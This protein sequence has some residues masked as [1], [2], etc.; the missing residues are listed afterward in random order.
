MLLIYF[1][2][3]NRRRRQQL[4][5]YLDSVTYDVETAKNDTLVNFPMPMVAFKLE[6]T[7]LVWGNHMF[8]DIVGDKHTRFDTRLSDVVH[9][10]GVKWLTEGKLQYPELV[11]VGEKLVEALRKVPGAGDVEL[12]LRGASPL[13]V[14]WA[15]WPRRRASRTAD[16]RTPASAIPGAWAW[17][18]PPARTRRPL[19]PGQASPCPLRL[20]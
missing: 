10:F 4:M 15:A 3:M 9:G 1:L 5:E 13:R 12:E 2:I 18:G 19:L 6:N 20:S 11:E 7:A 8:F 17:G 14:S 16:G